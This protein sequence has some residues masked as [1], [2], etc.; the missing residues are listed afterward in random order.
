MRFRSSTGRATLRLPSQGHARS[1]RWLR[2]DCR[3]SRLRVAPLARDAQCQASA[4]LSDRAQVPKALLGDASCS[5]EAATS[6]AFMVPGRQERP[7]AAA[8]KPRA[9]SS[10]AASG[11]ETT[12]Q[13][14]LGRTPPGRQRAPAAATLRRCRQ[15]GLSGPSQPEQRV[16]KSHVPS[17]R[18]GT[19]GRRFP[20]HSSLLQ[21]CPGAWGGLSNTREHAGRNKATLAPRAE[22]Y[23]IFTVKNMPRTQAERQH[24]KQLT[25]QTFHP[26]KPCFSIQTWFVPAPFNTTCML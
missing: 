20:V 9:S 26:T 17:P 14:H 7:C 16:P 10:F 25:Q 23:H 15:R 12:S 13:R 22:Q 19:H 1:E 18:H 8:S 2:Q 24:R 11:D 21:G 3:Q 5:P 6:G 4:W